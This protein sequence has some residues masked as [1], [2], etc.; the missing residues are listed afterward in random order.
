MFEE[1]DT[2]LYL[3][4]CGEMPKDLHQGNKV[5][6]AFRGFTVA[7]VWGRMVRVCVYVLG[8][9]WEVTRSSEMTRSPEIMVR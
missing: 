7:S 5:R 1:G 9:G 8:V 2:R 4:V 6:P 3:G